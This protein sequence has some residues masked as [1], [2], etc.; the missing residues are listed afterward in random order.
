MSYV[1][2]QSE[3]N[4]TYG[5]PDRTLE[6]GDY[7]Y[8]VWDFEN[9]IKMIAIYDNSFR[10]IHICKFESPLLKKDF[11]DIQ[12]NKTT[13]TDIQKKDPFSYLFIYEENVF[14][15]HIL[16]GEVL[17]KIQYKKSEDEWI[18]SKFEFLDNI[19]PFPDVYSIY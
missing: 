5:L 3:T 6:S 11:E 13:Y 14:S 8:D 15:E 7:T 2:R 18:V 19:L 9:N 10:L 4:D 16:S 12:V 17:L 1:I